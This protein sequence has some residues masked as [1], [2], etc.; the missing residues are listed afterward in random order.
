VTFSGRASFFKQ[1]LNDANKSL[2]PIGHDCDGYSYYYVS[3]N[4]DCRI[5]KENQYYELNLVVRNYEE[6][7]QLI[8]KFDGSRNSAETSLVKAIRELL[9]TLKE[10]DEEEKKKEAIFIRKHQAFDKAKKL[11]KQNESEK[12][13]TSDYFLMNISDHVIT[14]N[15]LNQI[16]KINAPSTSHQTRRQLSGEE[17]KKEKIEKERLERERRIEKRS[18][19]LEQQV[20]DEVLKRSIESAKR[21]RITMRKRKRN[22]TS[23]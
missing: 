6:I 2:I 3:I 17:I 11:T 9:L 8:A 7:E 18:K 5:Y 15:Q 22:K 13:Q 21:N 1:E 20:E 23:N 19:L 16:T 12:Y 10:N 4:K 14:R